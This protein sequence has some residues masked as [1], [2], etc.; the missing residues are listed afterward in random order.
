MGH[1]LT[2]STSLVRPVFYYAATKG[3]TADTILSEAGIDPVLLEASDNRVSID[4]M[5]QIYK[6]TM[7]LTKDE[8]LGLHVGEFFAPSSANIVGHI[9]M[10]CRKTS[11]ILKKFVEYNAILTEGVKIEVLREREKR[12][13]IKHNVKHA[14]ISLMRQHVD[15]GFCSTITLM[16]TL[17]GQV[18]TPIEVRFCHKAPRDISEHQRIFKAPLLFEHTMNAMVYDEK[19]EDIPVLQPNT[20]LLFFLELHAK[21]ILSDICTDRPFTKK[22]SSL[23]IGKFQ[24]R[25]PTIKDIA[26]E[27]SMSVRSLQRNL[28]KENTSYSNIFNEVY[29]K[30]AISYLVNENMPIAEIAYIMGFSEPSAFHR[31]F[32]RWT[33]LTPNEYRTTQT[34]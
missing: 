17:L 30:L 3:I 26:G 20:E 22:V 14:D 29:K 19:V 5:D 13:V 10:N 12:T 31:T 32:K 25:L 9:F 33:G 6:Q 15:Y 27:L 24:E 1:S 34:P 18:L 8:N 11:E 4:V 23:L 16:S 28:E 2:I 7:L 21:K